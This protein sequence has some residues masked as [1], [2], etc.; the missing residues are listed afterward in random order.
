MIPL[1]EKFWLISQAQILLSSGVVI[2]LVP[3]KLLFEKVL[4]LAS[5]CTFYD[6]H[7]ARILILM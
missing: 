2:S 3:R 7:L 6:L 5:L 4:L 1:T